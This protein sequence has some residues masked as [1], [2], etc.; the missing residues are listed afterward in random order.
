M[1][2]IKSTFPI[3]FQDRRNH[4]PHSAK[5]TRFREKW[6]WQ[7]TLYDVCEEKITQIKEGMQTYLTTFL[8]LLSY[9]IDKGD[10]DE[11]EMKYQEKRRKMEK[12]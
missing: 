1:D 12:N 2:A 8:M 3:I 7:G 5:F 6:S 4:R 9:Q 11:A 10:A